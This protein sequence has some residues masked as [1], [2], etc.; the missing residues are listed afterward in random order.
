MFYDLQ[1]TKRN[2]TMP[3]M[4]QTACSYNIVDGKS[5]YHYLIKVLPSDLS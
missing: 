2:N 3:L 5:S 1:S 4:A